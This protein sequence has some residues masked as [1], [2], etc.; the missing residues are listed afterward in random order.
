MLPKIHKKMENPPGRPIVSGNGCPT[1]KISQLVDFFLQPHV[2]LLPS[3]IKDTTHFLLKLNQLGNLP[4]NTILAP[5]DVASLYTNIPNTEG[6][7]AARLALHRMRSR[8]CHPSNESLTELLKMVLTMKTLIL[9]ADTKPTDAHNYLS[10][11]SCHPPKP[12]PTGSALVADW[13]GHWYYHNH[14]PPVINSYSHHHL[15]ITVHRGMSCFPFD[16]ECCS[17]KRKT[18]VK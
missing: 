13:A 3:Y 2:K 5:L 7:E 16:L 9:L 18:F 6:L 4:P 14:L 17:T 8:M 1:E 12:C 15:P 11:S 10:Y